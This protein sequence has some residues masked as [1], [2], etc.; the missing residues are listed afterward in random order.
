MYHI[1]IHVYMYIYIC[2]KHLFVFEGDGDVRDF[3]GIY[4]YNMYGCAY[5]WIWQKFVH[6]YIFIYIFI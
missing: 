3:E 6:E 1:N 4:S 5:K 2:I